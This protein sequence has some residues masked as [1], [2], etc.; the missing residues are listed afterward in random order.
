MNR[1]N[2]T[3]LAVFAMV[4]VLVFAVGMVV[5]GSLWGGYGMMGRG[6][7]GDYRGFDS[8]GMMGGYGGSLSNWVFILPMCFFGLGFLA[9]LA[10]GIVWL[11]RTVG[12]PRPAAPVGKVCPECHRAVEA[13]WK[14]CPHCGA[15][16]ESAEE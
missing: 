15:T 11:V 2:W 7:M 16:L 3:Q 14:A 10:V 1:I 5:L 12:G 8:G 6:M 13:G 9:L 4:V